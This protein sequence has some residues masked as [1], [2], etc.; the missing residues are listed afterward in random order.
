MLVPFTRH[1]AEEIEEERG[2]GGGTA[3]RERIAGA[4]PHLGAM[5]T[6]EI[7]RQR[8]EQRRVSAKDRGT[9]RHRARTRFAR[10]ALT[11]AVIRAVSAAS[12]SRPSGVAR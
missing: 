8:V 1:A 10:A 11:R 5:R 6:A 7:R 9:D 3:A 4:L 2:A 12:T